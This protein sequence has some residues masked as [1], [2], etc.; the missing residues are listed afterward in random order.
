MLTLTCLTDLKNADLPPP[1]TLAARHELRTLLALSG[2][3]T[4]D[5]E[6]GHVLVLEETD[7]PDV[8]AALLQRPIE[9]AVHRHGCFVVYFAGGGNEHLPCA[10][11][12]EHLL[13]DEHR[14]RLLLE[15]TDGGAP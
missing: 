13:T 9:G 10:V 6:F 7:A 12:P 4:I 14:Q 8:V 5:T 1:V 11:L 2:G 15:L 3:D